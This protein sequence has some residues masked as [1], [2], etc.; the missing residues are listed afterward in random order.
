MVDIYPRVEYHMVFATIL[1]LLNSSC[2]ILF[3]SLAC[4]NVPVPLSKIIMS[5]TVE[6]L[7]LSI[8]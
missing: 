1:F 7:L 8:Y 6:P 2:H 4:T 5:F 3:V